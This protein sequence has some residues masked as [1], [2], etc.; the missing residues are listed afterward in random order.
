VFSLGIGL[1]GTYLKLPKPWFWFGEILVS[2]PETLTFGY[3]IL[4][5][6]LCD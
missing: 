1:L 6:F 4:V 5:V 3:L 2:F